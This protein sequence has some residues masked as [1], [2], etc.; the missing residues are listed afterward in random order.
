MTIIDSTANVYYKK[1]EDLYQD[2]ASV[3]NE[4]VL[5]LVKN[6]CKFIQ[7]DEPLLA[8]KP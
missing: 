5:D 2:L 1:I 3:I 6:G 7:I 8:R 4:E